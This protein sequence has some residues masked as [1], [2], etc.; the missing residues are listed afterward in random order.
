[1]SDLDGERAFDDLE[2]EPEPLG[3]RLPDGVWGPGVWQGKRPRWATIVGAFLIL[4][5]IGQVLYLGLI[6]LLPPILPDPLPWAGPV[7]G[8]VA[9]AS[10]VGILRG[11]EWGRWLAIALSAAWLARS[12]AFFQS[13]SISPYTPGAPSLAL[14]ILLPVAINAGIVLL[15]LLRWPRRAD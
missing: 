14:D 7:L 10:A 1:M 4:N 5:A 12:V 15:L 13:W 11:L 8:G 6:P 2:P 9:L 3:S